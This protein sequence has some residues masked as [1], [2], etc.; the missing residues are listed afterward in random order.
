[1]DCVAGAECRLYADDTLLKMD[2]ANDDQSVLQKN[3]DLLYTWSQKWG[4]EFNP[5]KCAH[6][7]VG[8]K[9]PSFTLYLNGTEIPKA[10]SLKYLGVTIQNDLKW[11]SH[12]SNITKKANKTLGMLRRCLHEANF[13]TKHLAYVTVV[14]PILEYACQVWS[15][16][17]KGQRD[18]LERV[19]RRAVRW[20]CR[21]ARLD[22]V[23][24]KMVDVDIKELAVR[25]EELDL[26]F[27]RK[28]E[29]G[30][31]EMCIRDYVN[32]NEHHNTR[33]RG[34]NPHF[35]IDQF[36]FSFFNRMLE[37]VNFDLLIP[38]TP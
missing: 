30:M 7:S 1:M 15:P 25:R 26:Y 16:Y 24:D 33:S 5:K 8:N 38:R 23:S 31:V 13:R 9:F 34:I 27:L 29:F 28:A 6:I 32:F 2:L 35:N 18:A 17:L 21:L 19:Q 10:E 22:S 14:R 4:M 11:H 20:M 37:H 36:K 12:I 3:I